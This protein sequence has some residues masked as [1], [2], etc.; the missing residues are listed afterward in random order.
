MP[1]M[2]GSTTPRAAPTATAASNALPPSASTSRP[3]CVASGWAELTIPE[4]PTA[5]LDVVFWLGSGVRTA[6]VV[7]VLGSAVSSPTEP[8]SEEAVS[9]EALPTRGALSGVTG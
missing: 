9:S 4:A 8:S 7:G 1:D 2:Y 5:G 3:D 6:T